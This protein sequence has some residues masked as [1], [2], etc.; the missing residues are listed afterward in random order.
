MSAEPLRLHPADL[1]E[2]ADAIADRLASRLIGLPNRGEL[3]TAA[4]VAQRF[5][6]DRGWVY[7][8]ADELGGMRLGDG[9]R[10]RLRFDAA[11]L[12]EAVT[13]RQGGKTS[14]APEPAPRRGSHRRPRRTTGAATPLLP[15]RGADV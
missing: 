7:E 13:T 4:E 3:L 10:G 11:A 2:L 9:P 1:E 6:V 12:D 14:D 8:H 5:G 15:I